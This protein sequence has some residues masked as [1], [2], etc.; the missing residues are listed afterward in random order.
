VGPKNNNNNDNN[1]NDNNN[2][3]NLICNAQISNQ[4]CGQSPDGQR[5]IVSV[6]GQLTVV[7]MIWLRTCF[8]FILSAD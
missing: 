3:N 7:S 6:S 4:R 2:N 5:W 1:N 8:L